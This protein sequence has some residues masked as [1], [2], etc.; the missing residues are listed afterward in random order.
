[1]GGFS[2]LD[3]ELFQ[4]LSEQAVDLFGF[5]A[6]MRATS[7]GDRSCFLLSNP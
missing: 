5:N 6:R 7:W 2:L 3:Q 1:M 4:T